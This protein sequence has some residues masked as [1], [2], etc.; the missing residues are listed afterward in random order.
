VIG[1][2]EL[3]GD[4]MEIDG[5]EIKR[6]PRFPIRVTVQLYQATE[7][8]VL[9]GTTVFKMKQQIDQILANGS[10]I[11]SL[12]TE[13]KTD[14]I[15]EHNVPFRHYPWW[16]VFWPYAYNQD[17]QVKYLG[18]AEGLEL[19]ENRYG[20]GLESLLALNPLVG[21]ELALNAAKAT[22]QE[23]LDWVLTGKD[24]EVIIP[25]EEDSAE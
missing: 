19:L 22:L 25:T 6:D 1:H 9:D 5:L 20:Y 11:G 17:G 10:A 23:T 24:P 16:P 13:G 14:R 7:N 15:T 12:V 8:P 21:E 4:F 18:E 2:G 3:E